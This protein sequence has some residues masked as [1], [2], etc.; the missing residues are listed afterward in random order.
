MRIVSL[1]PS[2]TEIVYS[3]GFGDNLVGVSH[4]CDYPAAAKTKAKMIEPVFDTARLESER[5]DQLVVESI[6]RGEKLYKI[7][8]DEFRRANPDVVITQE[9][10][11]VCAIGTDDVLTAV[12]QLGK[13]VNV[14]SLNPHSLSDVEG[15]IRS[16][17]EALGQPSRAEEVI[18]KLE[19]KSEKIRK[20]TENAQKLRVF[21]VE[22]LK[23]LMNAGHWVPAM[24]ELAGGWDGLAK[25]GQPSTYIDWSTV[26]KYD[27]EIIIL[28]P[29][30][31]TK[32]KTKQQAR[33]FLE[34]PEAKRLS[35]VREGRV[36]ATDG[37]GYFSRSGP[38]LFD[39]IRILAQ[40]IHPEL[41]DQP[42]EPELASRLEVARVEL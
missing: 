10:C 7:R 26:S 14:V 12:S 39:G 31:F 35:A 32:A 38:R 1:L 9:L 17:A 6:K 40:I 23:P 30:G 33:Y 15:D 19:A 20:L 11:D 18:A 5:I 27:P 21:C 24:V 25:R 36:Y 28:M 4:E 22:W 34:N 41:F 2:A 29:C 42:M 13:P 16:V 8:L 3:L 37:H